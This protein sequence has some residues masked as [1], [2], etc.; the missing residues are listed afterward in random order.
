MVDEKL[1][2]WPGALVDPPNA[3]N[4]T[5]IRTNNAKVSNQQD[6][7]DQNDILEKNIRNDTQ[8]MKILIKPQNLQKISTFDRRDESSSPLPSSLRISDVYF[9]LPLRI[10]S[11]SSKVCSR[12]CHTTS[13]QNG[14][15]FF[16]TSFFWR[17]KGW[18]CFCHFVKM[19][20]T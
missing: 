1:M 10:D 17:C 5:C 20:C 4:I 11:S 6:F 9:F 15:Q 7:G 19:D 8:S 13:V 16:A 12:I 3:L 18:L 2:S 14:C